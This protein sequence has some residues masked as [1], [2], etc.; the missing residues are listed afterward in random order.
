MTR[1]GTHV[2]LA[3]AISAPAPP[4]PP[5][6]IVGVGA[7]RR[8][9]DLVV[10]D[11]DELNVY[12]DPAVMAHATEAIAAAGRDIPLSGYRNY[13]W[14]GWPAA[15]LVGDLAQA[16]DGGLSRVVVNVGFERDMAARV[17]E[18]AVAQERLV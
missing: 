3:G 12:L 18:L 2:R 4:S 13:D 9:I 6:V 10:Q 14:G 15:D 16:R 1:D 8:L 7:S 11:A 17:R 5:R